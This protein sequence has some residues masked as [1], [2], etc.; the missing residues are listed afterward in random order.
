MFNRLATSFLRVERDAAFHH[1]ADEKIR[2][3]RFRFIE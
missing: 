3:E 2:I 1:T